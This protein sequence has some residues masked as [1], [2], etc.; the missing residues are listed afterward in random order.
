MLFRSQT[1]PESVPPSS[2]SGAPTARSQA[3]SP[4]GAAT[5]VTAPTTPVNLTPGGQTTF[6]WTYTAGTAQQ[7]LFEGTASGTDAQTQQT[8]TS[9]VTQSAFIDMVT[10]DQPDAPPYFAYDAMMNAREHATLD[11][12]LE[13]ELVP[14]SLDEVILAAREGAQV[15]DT[16]DAGEFAR[17]TLDRLLDVVGGHV[18]ALR[19]RDDRPQAWIGAG[20]PATVA[21]RNRQFL[22]DAREDLAAL[23]VGRALLVLNRVPL[24]M[25]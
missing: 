19:F 10:A 22:D 13:R 3:A 21:G 18:D 1:A 17:A 8:V 9:P 12:V 23:G 24:G 16:R 4:A 11:Q 7:F 25:A 20:I 14:L 2:S 5:L 15:L 6:V